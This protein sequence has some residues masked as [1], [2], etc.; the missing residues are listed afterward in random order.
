MRSFKGNFQKN[1][2][3]EKWMLHILFFPSP[4]FS[5]G[6][7]KNTGFWKSWNSL[8]VGKRGHSLRWRLN[9][10]PQIA[11]VLLS[12][13]RV[14]RPKSFR[15]QKWIIDRSHQ[16]HSEDYQQSWKNWTCIQISCCEFKISNFHVVNSKFQ[17]F[18]LWIQNFKFS[19]CELKIQS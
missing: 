10:L 9:Q 14:F 12:L 2:F 5:L 17:I 4:H 15:C 13:Y 3:Y 7:R 19:C 1:I 16:S 11:L 8:K 6:C 18:M